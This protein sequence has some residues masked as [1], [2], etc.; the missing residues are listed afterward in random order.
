MGPAMRAV[1]P[2][3][4]RPAAATSLAELDD[5]IDDEVPAEEP[6]SEEGQVLVGDELD[7]T[8]ES[9]TRRSGYLVPE[10]HQPAADETV[11]AREL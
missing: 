9:A 11:H 2:Q 8:G 5:S 4:D 7:N 3:P 6:A 1:E 10:P